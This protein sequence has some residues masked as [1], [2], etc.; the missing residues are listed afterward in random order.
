MGR[1]STEVRGAAARHLACTAMRGQGRQ[2]KGR[3][4][5]AHS[6][7]LRLR[8][9]VHSDRNHPPR[10]GGAALGRGRA[11][12]GAPPQEEG[13]RRGGRGGRRGE[14]RLADGVS[15]G[16][17][18]WAGRVARDEERDGADEHPPEGPAAVGAEDEEGGLVQRLPLE[19]LG[20]D[21]SPV[22]EFHRGDEG[23]GGRQA[24]LH[25][26]RERGESVRCTAFVRWLG[27][28]RGLRQVGAAAAAPE[29]AQLE[30]SFRA[31]EQ[32]RGAPHLVEVSDPGWRIRGVEGIRDRARDGLRQ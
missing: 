15:A 6:V 14:E 1:K 19:Q 27:G 11:R 4:M 20:A 13:P 17:E 10:G 29:V 21:A 23:E 25:R 5:R 8:A 7:I 18:H 12:P 31:P 28:G 3:V 26:E 9:D 24:I 2:A 22:L 16:D 30:Q 32:E